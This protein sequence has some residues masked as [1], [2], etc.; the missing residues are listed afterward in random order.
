M[1]KLW[2]LKKDLYQFLDHL[3]KLWLLKKDFYQFVDH[4]KKL[5]LLKKGFYQ[6][7]YLFMGHVM[8]QLV[9]ALRCK[10]KGRG[11]DS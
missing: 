8:A 11:F 6:F 7:F 10:P 9:E 1:K 4:L 2:L 3:K 5:W